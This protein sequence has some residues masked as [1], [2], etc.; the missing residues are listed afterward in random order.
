M[1]NEERTGDLLGIAINNFQK[2]KC[3]NDRVR[4]Y[5]GGLLFLKILYEFDL[6]V[7]GCA[8]VVVVSNLYRSLLTNRSVQVPDPR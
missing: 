5:E 7:R 1:I 2:N 6:V 3:T 8:L 4:R